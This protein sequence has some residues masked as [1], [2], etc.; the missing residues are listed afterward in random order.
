MEITPTEFF[1]ARQKSK[2]KLS[3]LKPTS[4]PAESNHEDMLKDSKNW[5]FCNSV[6]LLHE[7]Y[8]DH[9]LHDYKSNDRRKRWF[10][11]VGGDCIIIAPYKKMSTSALRNSFKT[12][13]PGYLKSCSVYTT[14]VDGWLNTN[15]IERAY[16]SSYFSSVYPN[17]SRDLR[18]KN[19]RSIPT[20]KK[21]KNKNKKSQKNVDFFTQ[22][23]I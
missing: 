20:F 13:I 23:A 16:D 18:K 21:A 11:R 2:K 5:K 4:N 9:K 14:D 17:S 1:R 15:Y 10:S 19:T 7:E 12:T 3:K 8:A 6:L 22:A